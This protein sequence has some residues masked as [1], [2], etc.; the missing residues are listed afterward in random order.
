VTHGTSHQ[1]HQPTPSTE[2]PT[3]AALRAHLLTIADRLTTET[4]ADPMTEEDRLHLVHETAGTDTDLRH[5]LL[6]HTILIAP[7]ATRAGYGLILRTLANTMDV[8]GRYAAA[9]QK[10][11]GTAR[12][13]GAGY[14]ENPQWRANEREVEALWQ[15]ALAAGH[16]VAELLAA[17]KPQTQEA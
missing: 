4:P 10:S 7:G 13:V 3:E 17:T 12:K 1:A 16:S 15:Q 14:D 5:A 8:V 11:R 2:P 6:A 9:V